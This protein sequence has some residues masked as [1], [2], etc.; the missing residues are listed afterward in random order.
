[1]LLRTLPLAL[2]LSVA[3][4]LLGGCGA[5]EAIFGP[6]TF[7]LNAPATLDGYVVASG[8]VLENSTTNAIAVG[9]NGSEGRRGFVRFTLAGLPA[10][11]DIQSSELRLAQAA[12]SGV[13]YGS[14]GDV[15]MDHVDIGVALDAG[16]YAAVAL[17]FDIGAMSL[18]AAL[19]VK[20]LDVT[21]KVIEDVAAARTTSD[22]RLRFPIADD[23]DAIED[24]AHFE[25]MENHLFTNAVPVLVIQYK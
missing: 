12:V 21:A 13:P 10:G 1:M 18:T 6:E 20:V 16:D 9:D 7:T 11:A 5:G 17:D 25:D 15:R 24:S 23:G 22:F 14:L 4:G 3:A 19:D 2:S 8:G